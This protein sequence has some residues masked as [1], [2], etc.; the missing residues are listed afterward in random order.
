MP[1]LL[2]S[3]KAYRAAHSPQSEIF[4]PTLRV[5]E[6][7]ADAVPAPSR[8][9]RFRNSRTAKT[10]DII[11]H[12][13]KLPEN[14]V[15]NLASIIDN[16]ENGMML[17]VIMH[18]LFDSYKWCLLPTDVL[19][20]Y[21]VH[22]FCRVPAGLGNFTEVQF[23][24]HPQTGIRLLNPTFIALHAA[25]AYVLH[26]SDAAGIIDKVYDAFSDGDCT[27]PSV[28]RASEEDFCIRLLL[29]GLT[30]NARQLPTN[31]SYTGTVHP[32]RTC[33]LAWQNFIV[34]DVSTPLCLIYTT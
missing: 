18:D 13:T 14:I 2:D 12:Y 17:D 34:I 26:L 22:W 30:T 15:D 32:A 29:I 25:V 10:I 8:G 5:F 4:T 1:S 27:S 21:T 9:S 19:H 16:P 33:T 3:Q 11:K 28:D 23:Q 6:V 24:D 31:P 7:V 20:K